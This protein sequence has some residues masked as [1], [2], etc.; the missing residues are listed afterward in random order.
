MSNPAFLADATAGFDETPARGPYTLANSNSAIFVPLPNIT[1]SYQ[2]II[3]RIKGIVADG[4]ASTYLPAD[5]RTVPDLVAGYKSQLSLLAKLLANP[6]VPSIETTFATGT[7]FRA[8]NLHPLSRGTVRLNVTSPYQQP[9]VDYRTGS[10]PID[11]DVYIAHTQ[12][13]R[14]MVNTTTLQTYGAFELTPGVSVQGDAAL[15][16]YVQDSM[17]FSYMHPCCTAAM[18]PKDKGG[19]VGKDLKVHGA[20]GLR[21]VDMSVLPF[22]PSS[23]LSSVAYA[24]GEKVSI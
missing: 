5:Y 20:A 16:N 3:N 23:H 11:F 22:L 7:S 17:T 18:L 21:V 14:R 8:I 1:T 13:L 4:S 2:T 12:Y 9:I 15:L 10:N 19:V 6:R 24:Y